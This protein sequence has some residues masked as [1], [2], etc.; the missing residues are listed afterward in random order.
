MEDNLQRIFSILISVFIFFILPLYITYEKVDDISYSLVLKITSNFVDNVTSKGYIS[1]NM[2]EEFVNALET[3]HN[4]YDIKLEH[5]EKKYTPA[6]YV[7]DNNGQVLDVLD[8]SMYSDKVN[9]GGTTTLK[10]GEKEYEKFHIV[11]GKNEPNIALS[12]KTS[13]VKYSNKQILDVLSNTNDTIPYSKLLLTEYASIS[14]NDISSTP[15]MYGN[16]TSEILD[17]GTINSNLDNDNKIYTMNKGDEFSVRIKNT[18][19]SIATI[20]FNMIALGMGKE[21]NNVRVYINY[22]GTVGEE[23]YLNLDKVNK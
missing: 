19:T 9:D 5:I 10:V 2:Y 16:Y 1:K 20:L 8:Y 3:T 18:N 15:Y 6:Y 4:T 11:D 23:E 21:D 22:G 12:Y 13:E 7:Y 14:K 17:D